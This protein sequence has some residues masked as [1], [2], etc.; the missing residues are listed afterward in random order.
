MQK[1]HTVASRLTS[2]LHAMISALT[3]AHISKRVSEIYKA[4]LRAAPVCC[5]NT[6]SNTNNRILCG[7]ITVAV[8][9]AAPVSAYSSQTDGTSYIIELRNKSVTVKAG[10]TLVDI[11]K[12]EFGSAAY[13]RL[14]AEYNQLNPSVALVAGQILNLPI[15][16]EREKEFAV[17]AFLKGEATLLR[18]QETPRDLTKEDQIYAADIIKT[19]D[20]G[21]VSIEYK[22]GTVVNIQPKSELEFESI[23]CLPDDAV[24]ELLL[25]ANTGEFSS[26]VRRRDGQPT[27]FKILTPYASAAVRGTVFD[28]Q[29]N[30]DRMLVGVTEGNVA[31]GA[32]NEQSAVG[33]GFG[34]VAAEGEAPGDLIELTGPPTFR[35]VPAR[36]AAG[37]KISWWEV[38]QSSRYIVSIATDAASNQIVQQIRQ[39][40][41][42]F[43]FEEISAG[44]YYIS[45]RPVDN[46]GLKGFGTTQKIKLVDIDNDSPVFPL[47]TSRS[48][49]EVV[50][51][52][53]EPDSSIGGYEFQIATDDS[54]NDVISIDV[55]TSGSAIFKTPSSGAD[56]YFA[57]ARALLETDRVSRFGPAVQLN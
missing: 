31:V 32:N 37:D 19:G 52:V 30:P 10:E 18:K 43:Q 6:G 2:T 41:Q 33:V 36:F 23:R 27:D 11:A 17:V 4:L 53:S 29:A 49:E 24:C 51:S 3:T 57:R 40:Q 28:F 34:I 25:R 48:G 7:L 39:G 9:M 15:F 47:N 14:I 13:R 46:Q 16:L 20:N 42:V 21:F 45:V 26:D 44:E 35:G 55:G 56:Q 50:I 5:A 38:P 22:P 54:F 1:Q 8:I 12:R